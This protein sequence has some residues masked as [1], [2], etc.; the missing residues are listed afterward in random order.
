MGTLPTRIVVS[1]HA[2][3]VCEQCEIADK[4]FG[5]MKGLLGRNSLEPG[6][7]VLITPAP[8]IHT[9]F[10]RF[11]IDA[12][13]LDRDL[14]VIDVVEDLRPWRTASRLKAHAILELAAGEARRRQL[15]PGHRLS[16]LAPGRLPVPVVFVPQHAEESP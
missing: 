13:F 5:R 16:L 4:M 8:S 9:W 10:M 12:V 14:I 15:E 11:P 3:T 2:I 1:D 7:G 6:H